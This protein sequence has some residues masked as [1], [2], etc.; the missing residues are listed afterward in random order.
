MYSLLGDEERS[1]AL[2]EESRLFLGQIRKQGIDLPFMDYHE[3]TAAA[4]LGQS[5]QAIEL[6]ER[7][8]AGGFR[9]GWLLEMD[10]KLASIREDPGFL[11]LL[12]DLNAINDENRGQLLAESVQ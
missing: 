7:A 10:P 5:D 8:I 12:E 6:L 9:S 3:A 11:Q 1:A 4:I 2:V